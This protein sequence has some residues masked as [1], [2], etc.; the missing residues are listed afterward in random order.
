MEG[1]SIEIINRLRKEKED[2]NQELIQLKAIIK[3][4]TEE[5]NIL[6][7]R[8]GLNSTN[9]SLPPSRDLYKQKR[10]ERKKSDRN[11]GGQPGHAYHSYQPLEADEII[12]VVPD[13][14][15]CGHQV[16]KEDRY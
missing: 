16:E 8:L 14:C 2:L 3:K 12:E 4:L 10:E 1:S 11:A 13:K 9:S 5:L 6:K 15:S 7:E